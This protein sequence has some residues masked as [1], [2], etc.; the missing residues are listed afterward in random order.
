MEGWSVLS[1]GG[2]AVCATQVYTHPSGADKVGGK[3]W[4]TVTAIHGEGDCLTICE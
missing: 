4:Q 3:S 1:G 2:Q